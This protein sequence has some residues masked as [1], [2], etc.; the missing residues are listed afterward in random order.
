MWD[1]PALVLL[2]CI[3]GSAV[4]FIDTTVVNVALPALRADLGAGLGGQQWVVDAYLLTLGSLVLLGGSLG[5]RLG[6]RRVFALGVGGFGLASLACA[7]APSIGV[8]IGLRALQ[9]VFAALLVPSSLAIITETYRGAARGAAIG[10]WTAWTSAGIAFGP[11]LGGFLVDVLSWRAVFALNVPL[12]L[13][14]LLLIRRAVPAFPARGGSLD[15]VGA[16]LCALGLAGPVFGLIEEP[17]RGFGDPVVAGPL[18]AGGVL[19]VLFVGHE[20]RT[21][22]PML[23]LE[24]F[25]ARD[26][27]V[28]NAATVAI[29]AGLA[30]FTFL[31]AVYLQ[32]VAG[33][34]ATAA[35]LSLMPVTV[36]LVV[37]SRRFGALA[38]RVGPRPVMGIGPLVAAAGAL[39]FLRLGS[40][41]D[42]LT[43]L[44]PAA[45]LFG[46][47]MS[48]TV[49][50]LTATVLG[51][52]AP[53]RAGVASGVN[54]ALARVAGLLAIALVGLVVSVRFT[55]VLDAR[56]ASVRL[57]AAQQAQVAGVRSRPLTRASAPGGAGRAAGGGGP[58]R[59]LAR[60][61]TAASISAFRY[62]VATAALLVAAGGAIALIGLSPGRAWHT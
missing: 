55:G 17:G 61:A 22:E 12:V 39:L 19:L 13:A 56:L 51:A 6:R 9:G 28:A 54:N 37:F 47:G 20:R 5:D 26:F 60:A 24:L 1:P 33:Y 11:P 21:P 3:L 45:A 43:D 16:G 18:L 25:A 32:Q 59:E 34:S 40:H 42:Y 44:L 31:V 27:A 23:P 4:V 52:T 15:L 48:A 30:G 10:S 8:L 2:A 46:L 29:Y 35:G 14:T 58:G 57:P 49:A 38:A 50:P 41:V 36:M 53:G 7:L 62:G